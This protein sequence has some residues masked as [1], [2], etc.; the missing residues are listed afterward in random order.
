MKQEDS[1][2]PDQCF[3]RCCKEEVGVWVLNINCGQ[4]IGKKEY[5]FSYADLPRLSL[6]DIEDMYLL[7]VQDKL[8]HLQ[9]DFE[10][11]FINALLL[12]IR[13]DVIK[14]RVEDI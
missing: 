7:K 2:L 9:S 11:N 12:Y 14:Y 6:N 3:K 8:H 13:R 10:I 5:E 1:P 4:E